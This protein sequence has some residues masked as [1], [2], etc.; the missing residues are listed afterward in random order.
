M[1]NISKLKKRNSLGQPPA[2]ASNNLAAPEHAPSAV[3]PEGAAT[4]VPAA[5]MP[6][7]PPPAAHIDGRSLRTR[8][9]SRTIQFSTKITPEFDVRIR[10]TAHRDGMLLTELLEAALDA[11]ERERLST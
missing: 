8:R 2:E 1:T 10:Q 9:S 6:P 4:T 5:P 7:E 3:I 11:Y